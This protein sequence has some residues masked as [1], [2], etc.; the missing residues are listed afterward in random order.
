MGK[1][2]EMGKNIILMVFYILKENIWMI[3]KTEKEKNIINIMIY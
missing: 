1:E 2:I 3:W